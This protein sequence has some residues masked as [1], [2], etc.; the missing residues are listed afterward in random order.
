MPHHRTADEMLKSL[1][2]SGLFTHQRSKSKDFKKPEDATPVNTDKTDP[3]LPVESMMPETILPKTM[4]A[5][6]LILRQP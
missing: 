5:Q 3:L 1:Q 4:A 6:G 2:E